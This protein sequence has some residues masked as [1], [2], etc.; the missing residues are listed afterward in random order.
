MI[1]LSLEL[2]K[3]S[4]ALKK[5][6]MH[7]TTA[8]CK[9]THGLALVWKNELIDHMKVVHC[10]LNMD[11]LTSADTKYVFSILVCYYNRITKRIAV[12]HLGSVDVPSCTSENIYNET[13]KLFLHHSLLWE[14][15]ITLLADSA[16]TRDSNQNK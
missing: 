9:L 13:N 4:P 5:Y 8:S 10:S 11:K 14:K 6:K 2:S 16:N 3:D 7:R 15:L 1:E 12:E